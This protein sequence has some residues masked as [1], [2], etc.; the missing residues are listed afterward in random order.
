MGNITHPYGQTKGIKVNFNENVFFSSTTDLYYKNSI[1]F[2]F[3]IWLDV[4]HLTNEHRTQD[5]I[6]S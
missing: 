1:F 4:P 6:A 2:S 3:S 5:C